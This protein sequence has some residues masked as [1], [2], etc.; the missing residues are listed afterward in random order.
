L[1]RI[2][3]GGMGDVYLGRKH[4]QASGISRLVAV[5]VIH[6]H[7]SEEEESI[8]MFLDE[9]VIAA[10]LHH[11]N[12]VGVID[13]GR[14]DDRAFVVMDYVEGAPFSAL[15]KANRNKRPPGV[16]AAVLYEMLLG[17]QHAHDLTDERGDPLNL[18]HRDISPGNILVGVDGRTRLTDF[19][20]AKAESRI[21]HTRTGVRKGKVDYMSP[22]QLRTPGK[23]DH[24]SDIFAS[25]IVLWNALTGKHLFRGEEAVQTMQ[26]VLYQDIEKPSERGLQPPEAFDEVCLKALARDPEERFQSA[27]EMADALRKAAEASG[28]MASSSEV[29]EWV[30]VSFGAQLAHRREV[31]QRAADQEARDTSAFITLPS[32]TPSLSELGASG[33]RTKGTART[34]RTA[35]EEESGK[36][37]GLLLL[38]AVFLL[39]L[40]A[41]GAIML[42]FQSGDG[43]GAASEV[44]PASAPETAG[45]SAGSEPQTST[46]QQ[47]GDELA[48]PG[49]V[50]EPPTSGAEL[51]E[52]ERARAEDT[53][54]AGEAE[55]TDDTGAGEEAG[56]AKQETA[57]AKAA[58][59]ERLRQRWLR[60]RR[61]SE[62]RQARAEADQDTSSSSEAGKE[63]SEGSQADSSS[64][65]SAASASAES[66]SQPQQEQ[67]SKPSDGQS[68]GSRDRLEI[69]T[70]PYFRRR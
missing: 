8:Q 61:A 31:V 56:E 4:A 10:R 35:A 64:D 41:M 65:D 9:A 3:R 26:N 2:G 40:G 37:R 15:L 25:G 32:L 30:N 62:R 47:R 70:N 46:P 69:E 55:P 59:Q 28:G 14:Q 53:T 5:K 36:R 58:R 49:T 51:T 66:K 57:A 17:L 39:G 42:V 27:R 54:A 48:S 52:E 24:R 20:V 45:P 44:T 34:G 6:P 22:E 67:R 38:L 21:T 18:V 23:I 68:S 63:S 12:T 29:A 7:L 1:V 50:E 11:S 33:T 16:V 60:Q 19:G 13:M 43:D